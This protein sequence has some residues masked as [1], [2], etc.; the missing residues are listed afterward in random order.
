MTNVCANPLKADGTR[1]ANAAALT[2]LRN[3]MVT[4]IMLVV[5]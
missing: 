4:G 2:I 3:L 1:N 5:N